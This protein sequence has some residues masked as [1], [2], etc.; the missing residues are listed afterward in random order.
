MPN[1]VLPLTAAAALVLRKITTLRAAAAAER[2]RSAMK[3]V[4]GAFTRSG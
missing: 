3:E 1:E 4:I 2:D